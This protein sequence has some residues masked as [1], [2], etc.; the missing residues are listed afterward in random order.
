MR[1]I[2]LLKRLPSCRAPM[3]HRKEDSAICWPTG[4]KLRWSYIKITGSKKI[5]MSGDHGRKDYDEVNYMRLYAEKWACPR[6]TSSWTTPGF[7]HMTVST[8]PK[9]FSRWIQLLWIYPG[10]PPAQGALRG[11]LPGDRCLRRGGGQ[12]CICRRQAVRNCVRSP[13]A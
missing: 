5:I 6:R 9:L 11:L 1:R 3:S 8:G 4:L 2:V 10:L 13:P 12:A 7:Q